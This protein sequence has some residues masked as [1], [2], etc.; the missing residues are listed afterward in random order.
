MD[1]YIRV[2]NAWSMLSVDEERALVEKLYYYGDL[3]V[4]KT[5]I[6]FY[7]RFVVYI[8]RNYAGYGLL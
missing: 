6:L 8:V 2:V 1:F 4:V 7:L 5:L 3:E